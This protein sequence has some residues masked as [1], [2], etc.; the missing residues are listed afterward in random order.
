MKF[1]LLGKSGLKVSDIGHGLWG[2]GA[3]SGSDDADSKQALRWSIEGGCNFF[4]SAFVYG[5]GKSDHLI[6]EVAGEFPGKNLILA[7]KIPPADFSWPSK[8]ENPLHKIFPR[9]H[10]IEYAEKIKTAFGRPIDLLQFH[11]WEDVW[12]K[13]AE[14]KETVAEL[15]ET[16]LIRAF[17]LSL[18][19]WQPWNGLAA[20][21][22]GLIDS[23]QVIYNIF[24][25]AP[26]DELFPA[27]RKHNVG[28]IARVPLDE[29]SLGGKLTQ[30]TRFP[31]TDWRARYFNAENLAKTLPRIDALKAL[32]PEGMSLPELALRFILSEPAVST[33]I[34]GMR[35]KEHVEANLS[36]SDKGALPPALIDALR[37][38]RWDRAQ[39]PVV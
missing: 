35:K 18:N 19:R 10:V 26:E 4:D 3:W 33:L 13:E 30:D 28:V 32:L 8:P 24:D 36:Y 22:T 29:G 37:A 2:M 27:C 1:R 23:V 39:K 14:W 5:D 38:H 34:A 12:A 9:A 16:G 15:K 20:I 11:V 31:D 21:E 25:Q 7:S 6:G 17:G